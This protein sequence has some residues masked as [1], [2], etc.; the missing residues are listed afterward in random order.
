M[1]SINNI[2]L[3]EEC[4][5]EENLQVTGAAATSCCK[6]D[7]KTSCPASHFRPVTARPAPQ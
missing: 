4:S 5:K 6:E 2:C 1:D 3:L 7:C